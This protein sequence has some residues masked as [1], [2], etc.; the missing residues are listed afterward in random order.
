MSKSKGNVVT[1]EE[2]VTNYGADALRV[3]ELFVAPFEQN[4]Q[5][6]NEGMAGAVRFLSRVF[7]LAGKLAQWWDPMWSMQIGNV[8]A[9]DTSKAIRRATHKFVAK[10]T[11]DIEAFAFNTYISTAMITVNTL[12]DLVKAAKDPGEAEKLA[13][14]EALEYLIKTLSPVA[15]HSADE[16]WEG[17]GGE[18]FTY[19]L[20]WPTHDPVLARDDKVTVAI[21][22]N[23]KLR[24]TMDVDA[25]TPNDQ[26]ESMALGRE[27]AIPFLEGKTVRK[28]IV[29]PGKLVNIVAS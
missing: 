8:E 19:S 17:L 13:F 21:Q 29:V 6:T 9:T 23:G 20:S 26:L 7:D 15:P 22:V 16:I 5:W 10:A 18:G 25:D 12:G 27:K 28:V 3:F 2:A 14:S 24:D 11:A 1:P 4:V